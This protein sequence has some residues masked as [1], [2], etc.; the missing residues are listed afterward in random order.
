[1][2]RYALFS[3]ILLV[4]ALTSSIRN[5]WYLLPI[6]IV[7]VFLVDRR[8][9]TILLRW[10]FLLFLGILVFGIPI[11]IGQRDAL[12][13]GIPYSRDIFRMSVEMATRSVIILIAIKTFTGNISVEQMSHG[14]QRLRL[15]RF[16]EVFSV[17]MNLL[18][19][20]REIARETFQDFR[21]SC[22]SYYR[23]RAGFHFLVM[24]MARLLHFA[25]SYTSPQNRLSDNS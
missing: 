21:Q 11:F 15:V 24:L 1:M 6:A 13:W 8:A 19:R 10:K 14:F 12:F 9:L 18:P 5:F 3:G 22:T 4:L 16:S 20:I 25:E 7:L 23:P 17:S 2:K